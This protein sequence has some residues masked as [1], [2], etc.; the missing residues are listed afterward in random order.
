VEEIKEMT[1]KEIYLAS[2]AVIKNTGTVPRFMR[3]SALTN[4]WRKAIW[5]EGAFGTGLKKRL[6]I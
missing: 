3:H 2:Q 5:R 1:D 4:S 6:P